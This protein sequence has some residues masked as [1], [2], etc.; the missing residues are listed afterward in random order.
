MPKLCFV[1]S[2]YP[3]L[4]YCTTVSST[5]CMRF[6]PLPVLSC[7]LTHR[8]RFPTILI[9][10]PRVALTLSTTSDTRWFMI[11]RLRF[12]H[13]VEA[14]FPT[15]LVS[16]TFSG[17]FPK[18]CYDAFITHRATPC[19]RNRHLPNPLD[20]IRCVAQLSA[21]DHDGQETVSRINATMPL[22]P[23]TQPLLSKPPS[24]YSSR[25]NS[26]RGSSIS[27]RA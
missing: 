6:R 25:R 18:K 23:T 12:H 15:A 27:A 24:S 14:V 1:N 22:S 19:R 4:F 26:V 16:C 13:I 7:M 2:Y 17:P 11:H 8:Q 20:G 10:L 5:V 9:N 3:S 21:Q